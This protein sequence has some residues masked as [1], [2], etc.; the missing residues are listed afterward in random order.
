[1]GRRSGNVTFSRGKQP[2]QTA[3]VSGEL[4]AVNQAESAQGEKAPTYSKHTFA[5]HVSRR[6]DA[7]RDPGGSQEAS[8]QVT[9]PSVAIVRVRRSPGVTLSLAK[10]FWSAVNSRRTGRVPE[11]S[12]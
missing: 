10:P 1:M 8:S 12:G 3:L 9:S 7:R 6:H 4:L 11:S 5:N 2:A